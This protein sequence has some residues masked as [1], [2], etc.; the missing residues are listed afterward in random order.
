MLID[1]QSEKYLYY[2]IMFDLKIYI[3]N[4]IYFL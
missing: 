3:N 1:E 2:K 4:I